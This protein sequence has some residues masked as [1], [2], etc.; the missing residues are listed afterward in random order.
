MALNLIEGVRFR[1]PPMGEQIEVVRRVEE[2]FTLA[3]QIETR[4][5]EAK[6]QVDK[7]TQSILAKTFRGELMPQ[8]PND[9]PAKELLK[10][11]REA[12]VREQGRGED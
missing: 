5:T 7:L 6:A 10:R 9:E 2:L 3:D 4:Y 8:D 11:I 1:L 12:C